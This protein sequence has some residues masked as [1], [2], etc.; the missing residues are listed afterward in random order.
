MI[1]VSSE[2]F[3]LPNGFWYGFSKQ[4]STYSSPFHP[5]KIVQECNEMDVKEQP[6]N[7]VNT[8]I[9]AFHGKPALPPLFMF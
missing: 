6:L 9:L 3:T 1:M 5:Q 4:Q 2:T 8:A 7:T